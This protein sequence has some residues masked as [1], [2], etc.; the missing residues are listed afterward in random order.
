ML[1]FENE[2][3]VPAKGFEWL[4]LVSDYG[5]VKSLRTLVEIAPWQLEPKLLSQYVHS[6]GYI[7]YT[8]IKDSKKYYMLAHRLVAENYLTNTENYPVVNHKDGNKTNCHVSNL[9]WCSQADNIHHAYL[10]GLKEGTKGELNHLS[11]LSSDQVLSIDYML[12]QGIPY[13]E[14]AYEFNIS[15]ITVSDIKRGKSWSWLTNREIT[16]PRRHITLEKAKEVF[17]AGVLKKAKQ[18]E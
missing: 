11:V 16:S 18:K 6:D 5:R 15:P 12:K 9:E 17:C 14:I 8:F 4:Y 3:W 1:N 7:K 10:T 2:N 13:S